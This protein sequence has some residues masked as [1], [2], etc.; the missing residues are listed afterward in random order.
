MVDFFLMAA[1]IDMH[2]AGILVIFYVFLLQSAAGPT[3]EPAHT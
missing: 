2:A 3:N 1:Q